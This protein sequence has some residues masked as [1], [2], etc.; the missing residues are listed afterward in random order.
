[1]ITLNDKL[2][3]K[4]LP[5]EKQP[6]GVPKNPKRQEEE[7]VFAAESDEELDLSRVKEEDDDD[8]EEMKFEEPMPK[9]SKNTVNDD[10]NVKEEPDTD[11]SEN[12]SEMAK[13][14]DD[15]L[16]VN[17]ERKKL[18]GSKRLRLQRKRHAEFYDQ[19]G[20]KQISRAGT[21]QEKELMSLV[22]GDKS[23]I[24]S[25]LEDKK[26]TKSNK[27]AKKKVK[28]KPGQSD[29]AVWHDS[30]DDDQDDDANRKRNKYNRDQGQLTNERRRKQFEQIVGNPRWADLNRERERSDSE[31]EAM[32]KVGHVVKGTT[33]HVLPKGMIELK[34]LKNLNRETKHEGEITS[35]NFHP[36]SMVAIITG[37]SGM[38]SIVA[39]DGVRNEKLH[40]IG[41]EKFNIACARLSSGGNEAIFGGYRKFF[42]VYNL[43]SGESN[44]IKIPPL[45]TWSMKSFRISS[46]GEYL[47]TVGDSGEVHVLSAKGKELLWT[48]Q[49]RC[50]CQALAFTP[51]SRYL[52]CHSSDTEVTVYSFEQRR[53]VNVFQD[54]GCVNGSAIAVSPSGQFVA[55]GSR[56]GVVNIY[57]L[58]ETIEKKFPVPHKS[59]T[60]LTTYIDSLTFN[61][62]SELLAMA[63]ST[64]PN[65]VKL[66]HVK[67]GTVFRNFPIVATSLGN[68]TT[69]EFSPSG[70]FLAIG[71]KKSVVSLF[72]V[73]H[74]QNY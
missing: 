30:D 64:I 11:E 54:E 50:V 6:I 53:I 58:D 35:I 71:N 72:R 63:S 22:F 37:K 62:T 61:A 52:L 41:L 32:R 60:N 44:T 70:G 38:V 13:T 48:I 20:D 39:V 29:S 43:L 66:V 56:Q 8:E 46:C 59:I 33:S 24:V 69:V 7:Y 10:V 4:G 16:E 17:G 74:Y 1:M 55:T 26:K 18:G 45:E 68:V 12:Y 5:K 49:L 28:S 15:T 42:H 67:S 23:E 47:A 9:R 51:D 73:K 65:A 36:T 2:T 40:T 31:D 21:R 14:E 27:K 3:R 57:S 19:L 25:Q 34:K